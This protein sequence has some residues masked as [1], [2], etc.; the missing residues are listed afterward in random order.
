MDDDNQKKGTDGR[1]K[2]KEDLGADR[3]LFL[4]LEEKYE[5]ITNV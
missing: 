2:E 1:K 3:K 4:H 5:I